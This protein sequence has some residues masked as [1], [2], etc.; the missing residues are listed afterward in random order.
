[1]SFYSQEDKES[2]LRDSTRTAVAQGS[3]AEKLESNKDGLWLRS[4]LI[5]SAVNA[6]NWSVDK[7]TLLRN[8]YSIVGQPLVL[9]Q[10][11]GRADHPVYD[12]T[13]SKEAN[14]AQQR[15]SA[16]GEVKRVWY[17]KETDAYY[18]DSL[19]TDKRA[20]EYINSFSSKKIPIQVSPQILYNE[21]FES[22]NGPYKNWEFSHLAIVSKAA[23][24][25]ANVIGVCAGD[26]RTC[27]D[28][29]QK[30]AA[31]TAAASASLGYSL[32]RDT[33]SA[34]AYITGHMV[35]APNNGKRRGTI[36]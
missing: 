9:D 22:P 18:A 6:R 15:K 28:K 36:C 14:F 20:K 11:D 21:K 23:Y 29:L 31:V 1:M 25:N 24:P 4:F 10:F 5:S 17:D 33:S 7:D 26:G 32:E 12:T 35:A 2:L 8:V 3:Y 34:D 19:V 27:K 30:A 16:I 13:K